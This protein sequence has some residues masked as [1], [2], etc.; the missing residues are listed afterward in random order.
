MNNSNAIISYHLNKKLFPASLLLALSLSTGY[1][2]LDLRNVRAFS[3]FLKLKWD[4]S[5]PGQVSVGHL[6]KV[7]KLYSLGYRKVNGSRFDKSYLN[8]HN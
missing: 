1:S 4:F 6:V 5:E 3:G 7:L 2:K 8:L